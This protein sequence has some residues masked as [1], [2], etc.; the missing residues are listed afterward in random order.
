MKPDKGAIQY[1]E[2][3]GATAI[4]IVEHGDHLR[5]SLGTTGLNR[6]T[7]AR[8]WLPRGR[9][10]AVLEAARRATPRNADAA[11]MVEA[12]QNA[13]AR[14]VDRRHCGHRTCFGRG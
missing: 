4:S 12:L 11:I 6:P 13:A 9:V 7:L 10:D 8:F 2:S 1:L 14:D 3:A 5:Y